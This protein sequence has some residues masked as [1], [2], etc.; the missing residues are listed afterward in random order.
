MRALKSV[1]Q[2][3]EFEI[4]AEREPLHR[5]VEMFFPVLEQLVS[6]EALQN[7]PNYIPMMVLI[8]KVFYISI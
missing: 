7:S 8:T 5:L 1:F 3:F 2:A 6:S 4:K